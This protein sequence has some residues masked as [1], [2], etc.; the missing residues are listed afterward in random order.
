MRALAGLALGA[1]LA[2]AA[3]PAAAQV[4]HPPGHSPY[5]EIRKGHSVTGLF[6]HVGGSGGTFGIAPHSGNSYGIRY[7][8]RSGSAV[9]MGLGFERAHLERLIVDP[10]VTLATRTSG[11]VKQTVTFAEF[12]L[13]LNL[14]GG[15]SWHRLAPF[16]GS[17][18]GL[19]FPSG[20][21]ADT[22]GFEFG[23]RFYLAPGVGT[24]IFLS[25]RLHIRAELRATF[26]KIKYPSSFQQEPVEE[27]GTPD[28]PNAV[29][30][31]GRVSE[32]TATPWLQVGLGYNFSP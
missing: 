27:P 23:K 7:D 30:S 28:N 15:K 24:R 26:W 29:I 6:G 31:D 25:S 32:W 3:H 4:G 18:V 1:V 11:P 14:T 20:T 5:R 8:I 13:V 16:V 22:S 17:A 19:T 21:P 12:N 10:F 2:I 9:Q